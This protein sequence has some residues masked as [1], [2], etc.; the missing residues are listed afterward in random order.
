MNK[1]NLG[2]GRSY[3]A[4][5]VNIDISKEVKAEHYLD[6]RKDKLPFKDGTVE[7][8][9]VSGVFE[10]ILLNEDLVFAVNECHRVLKDGGKMTVVVPNAKYVIAF[11]DPFD[12]RRFTEDTWNYLDTKQEHYKLYGSVYGFKGW[13]VLSARTGGNGIQTVIM[14]K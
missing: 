6:I 3:M 1:I 14:E 7:E 9:L 10:Q 2:C 13:N 11:R 5:W 8:I 4:G 12:C